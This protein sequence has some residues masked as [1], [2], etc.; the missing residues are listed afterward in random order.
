MW[1]ESPNGGNSSPPD[2]PL[3][4]QE[5][6][7]LL[8]QF[9]DLERDFEELGGRTERLVDRRLEELAGSQLAIMLRNKKETLKYL[10]DD[11]ADLR[12]AAVQLAYRHW[13]LHKILAPVYK[14]MAK[15]D[16]DMDVRDSAIRALGT[17]F[18]AS[19][20]NQIGRLLAEIIQDAS[21]PDGIRLT[22]F[23]SLLRLHGN[24]DYTGKSPLV[25]LCLKDVDW[26]LVGQ[27]YQD[28]L[29]PSVD[30]EVS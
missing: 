1:N 16:P 20:E 7:F 24:L 29:N 22:A 25:P 10:C 11:K 21:L 5:I 3:S 19:K 8:D 13:K 4:K 27:Y 9:E 28:D 26:D 14:R 12:Q 6:A 30:N 15:T 23:T 18:A 17:S 2:N